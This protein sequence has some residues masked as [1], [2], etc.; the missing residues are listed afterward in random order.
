M[1]VNQPASRSL[2]ELLRQRASI[3]SDAPAYTFL[4][5]GEREGASL[6][7]GELERRSRAIAAE[8][9]ARVPARSRVLV[10]CPPGLDFVAAFFG[11]VF[12]DTI[13]VPTYPPAGGQ[14]DRIAERIRGMVRDAGVALVVAPAALAA[15]VEPIQTVVPELRGVPWLSVDSASDG[16][17]DGWRDPNVRSADIAFLQYTSGSTSAPRGVMV[18]HGNLLHNLR[19]SAA[20]AGHDATSASVS[21]LPVNHDMGLIEGVLQPAY[22][23]FPAY[24]MSPAAFLQR[25]VRWLRAISR[26]RAT[27]SGAPNFAYDLCVRRVG[28]DDRRTLDLS[29]WRTAFNGSEPV[30]R[31]TL[32]SFQRAFGECGFR[33]T[34]FRPAY[35]LAEA[36]LL[37]AS[38]ASGAGLT[39]DDSRAAS[40][41][42]LVGAGSPADDM[43]VLIVDPVTRVKCRDGSVGEIWISGS[44]VAAGYW[45]RPQETCDTFGASL[46][47]GEGPF[48]RSGDLGLRRDGQLFV[49]G[50]LKD[51]IIIRG[52]KH[53]PHDLEITAERAHPSIRPGCCAAVAVQSADEEA[54]ALLAEVDPRRL[55]EHEET[56]GLMLSLTIDAIR[57]AI[58]STHRVQLRAVALL[59]AG[60]LP[61]TTSG[62]LRRYLCR[63]AFLTGALP[64]VAEWRDDSWSGVERVA[65]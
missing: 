39:F 41:A 28:D 42:S 30:R 49:T 36:T 12:A 21:W 11:T 61:K 40:E 17:A 58:A 48:L 56:R 7:W 3:Q 5:S 54:I 65:S 10:M 26:L 64:S 4:E 29:S 57:E 19:C 2:V 43:R 18:T 45:Q 52:S 14:P 23:G 33:W 22:S 8:I 32:E 35:G 6:T 16:A 55:S 31:S 53:Y 27:H 13:A 60:T 24:L 1:R 47:S 46:A 9:V 37:V 15:R 50:R 63:T 59:P 25:P 44:S 51:V 34:A 62:K 38:S 20:L